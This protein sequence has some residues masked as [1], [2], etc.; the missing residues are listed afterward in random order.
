[1]GN[2]NSYNGRIAEVLAEVFFK[3]HG[4]L[5]QKY[6]IE[7][8]VGI[9]LDLINSTI[10]NNPSI[11]TIISKFMSMPD[12]TVIKLDKNR[13][14]KSIFFID[15][16]YR[17]YKNNEELNKALKKNGELHNQSEKYKNLWDVSVFI[18]LI[19]KIEGKIFSCYDS[20]NNISNDNFIKP[21]KKENYKWLDEKV[22]KEY[23]SKVI[24]VFHD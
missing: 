16:K 19:A 22:L 1:M 18:F 21:L 20:V 2:Y 15:V 3:K 4:F 17:E 13:D 14:L 23:N 12:F 8:Q 10:S 6:G 9:G 5:V 11:K 24:N 7:H